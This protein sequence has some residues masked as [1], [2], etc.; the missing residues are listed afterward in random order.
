MQSHVYE[1]GL[2]TYQLAN[3][4]SAV[5]GNLAKPA[6]CYTI[7]QFVDKGNILEGRHVPRERVL[8]HYHYYSRSLGI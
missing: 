6:N 1:T 4:T 8:V 5:A 2:V 3:V 7:P